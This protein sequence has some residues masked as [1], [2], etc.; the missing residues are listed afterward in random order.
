MSR[1]KNVSTCKICGEEE[2]EDKYCF[3]HYYE[4]HCSHCKKEIIGDVQGGSVNPDMNLC[5]DCIACGLDSY[6]RAMD[7]D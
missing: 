4:T 2:Y 1:F 5:E 3:E 6:Y 7:E